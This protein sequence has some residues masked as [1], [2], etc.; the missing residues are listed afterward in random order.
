[1]QIRNGTEAYA[2]DVCGTKQCDTWIDKA[3]IFTA[4]GD[5]S[6]LE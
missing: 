1:M 5:V 6:I 3:A 2:E 4:A